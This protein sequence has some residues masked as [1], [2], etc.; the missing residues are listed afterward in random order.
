MSNFMKFEKA[1]EVRIYIYEDILQIVSN[2][3]LE[4]QVKGSFLHSKYFNDPKKRLT[5]ADDLD[6]V[7]IGKDL[8]KFNDLNK[9]LDTI[10]GISK[11]IC[12]KIIKELQNKLV[13][14]CDVVLYDIDEFYIYNVDYEMEEDFFSIGINFGHIKTEEYI[15][16]G[17]EFSDLDLDLEITFGLKQYVSTCEALYQ[18][19]NK[20]EFIIPYATKPEVQVAWK[21]HQCLVRTRVKDLMD[22]GYLI[23]N[24][25]FKDQEILEN[26][27]KTVVGEC[28][29]NNETKV[30]L[31]KKLKL[32]VSGDING[33]SKNWEDNQY[34]GNLIDYKSFII[35]DETFVVSAMSYWLFF[36]NSIDNYLDKDILLKLI[37]KYS[38]SDIKKL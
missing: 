12:K 19:F 2:L 6:F 18:K 13:E 34:E 5:M 15:M 24:I 14:V 36:K 29:Y 27:A 35:E 8:G 30:N 1:Q 23:K 33:L 20:E 10:R 3:N 32:L 31:I 11:S 4:L 26:M 9:A 22:L 28:L 7:Y 21:L 38:K 25:N 17:Y 37:D 16:A